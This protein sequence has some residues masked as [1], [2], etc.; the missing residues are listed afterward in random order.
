MSRR[1]TSTVALLALALAAAAPEPAGPSALLEEADA[2]FARGEYAAA[3]TLYER[4]ETRASDPGRVTLGLAAAK[5]RLA[6]EQP[7][8]A[9][10]L[11]AEAEGLYRCCLDPDEP[12]RGEALLGLGNC[13]L[14]KA[15]GRDADAADQAAKHFAEAEHDPHAAALADAARH[16]LQRARLL[17]RQ[18]PTAPKEKPGEPPPGADTDRDPKPPDRGT[19]PREPGDAAEGNKAGV[20]P[21]KADP[22]QKPSP[23]DDQPP[24]GEGQQLP[25]V[26]ERDDQPP[27][28]AAAA[29]EHLEQAGRRIMEEARNH[30]RGTARPPA[31]GVR[32]W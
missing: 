16:N 31:P 10:A 29:R 14:R 12:R 23:T 8:R 18:I 9:A 11:L 7:A 24:P 30:R 20:A 27:L 22:G 26:P 13:L 15:A 25:P 2:A 4:A 32:D 3:V 1:L 21:A 5:Y 17:A 6:Q 19:E 28:T